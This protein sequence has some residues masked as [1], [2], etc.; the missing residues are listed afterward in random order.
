MVN[1]TILKLAKNKPQHTISDNK[2]KYMATYH[3][4][5]G[6]CLAEQ[7][8]Q[9]KINQD[10]IVCREVLMEGDVAA[11]NFDEFWT[12]R[13][14][15]IANTYGVSREEYYS[16][17]VSELQKLNHLPENAEVCL[18]FEN[19]L[20]CQ[21]NMWF[22]ISM[23]YSSTKLKI[24]RVFP[25]IETTA[26]IWKGFGISRAEHLEQAYH[27][28]ILLQPKD[29][30]LGNTL[31][32]AYKKGDFQKLKETSQIKS[33]A[34]EYLEGVCQAHIDRF[35]TNG[36]PGRPDQVVKELL[37]LGTT[38]FHEIFAEFSRREGIYGFGDLQLKT[39]YKR[40]M[41]NHNKKI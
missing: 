35:P 15:F 36:K 1:L 41:Q 27:S 21:V 17:T 4:L 38:K 5:N 13:A 28:K 32:T 39:I 31:W 20:F 11:K 24:Y 6:D 37:D 29:V 40:Q 33:D 18:W 23:L 16:K 8:R 2:I 19:D 7:L 3:I 14:Q 12:V 9:T 34:F 22:V 26:D 25:V 30:A 10:F